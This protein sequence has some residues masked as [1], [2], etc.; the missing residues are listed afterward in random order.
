MK[1]RTTHSRVVTESE[2]VQ[3]EGENGITLPVGYRNFIK[4]IGNGGVGPHYGL[5]PLENGKFIDLDQKNE[6]H[7]IDLSK[8]FMYNKPWNLNWEIPKGVTNEEEYLDA[9]Y[10]ESSKKHHLNGLLR[11]SNFG[12]GVWINLV[13]K[14]EEYGNIWIDDIC[15]NQGLAPLQT[16]QK[17]RVDFLEWYEEWLNSIKNADLGIRVNRIKS[18]IKDKIKNIFW[19]S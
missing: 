5:E 10:L 4:N 7:L 14:G 17:E 1:S 15:N 6:N 13:V 8:P 11:I 2:I 12:C 9:L 3:F 18:N 19:N 16:K